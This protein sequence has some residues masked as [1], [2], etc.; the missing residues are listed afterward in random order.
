MS[1]CASCGS[2]LINDAFLCPHHHLSTGDHWAE[3]NR[4]FCDLLHRGKEPTPLRNDERYDDVFC[5]FS[6]ALLHENLGPAV[7]REQRARS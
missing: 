4:V 6:E 2:A 3:A 7:L 5:H 1:L